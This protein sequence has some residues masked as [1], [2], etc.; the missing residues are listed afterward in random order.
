MLWS[1]WKFR[2]KEKNHIQNVFFDQNKNIFFLTPS[3]RAWRER[4]LELKWSFECV[5]HVQTHFFHLLSKQGSEYSSGESW[6]WRWSKDLELLKSVTK[7]SNGSTKRVA[8]YRSTSIICSLVATSEQI[9]LV[10][11]Y[12]ATRLVLPFDHFVTDFNNSKSFDHLQDQLSPE[13]YSD[14][15]FDN[16]WKKCVCTCRT[17]SNDHFSSNSRSRQARFEGVRKNIFLF[18]SKKTFWIWFFSLNLNFQLDQSILRHFVFA[19]SSK[20]T[21]TYVS[22]KPSSYI[23]K[24]TRQRYRLSL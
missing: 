12:S 16:R 24:K 23:E 17:H 20:P 19:S 6:S 8:E 10:D 9:M 22:Q 15:C 18:W 7:W 13:L 5:L 14:P 2:F 21:L 11:R 4:E 3:N 1:S